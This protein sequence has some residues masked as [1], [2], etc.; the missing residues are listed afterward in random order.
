MVDNHWAKDLALALITSIFLGG[1]VDFG[2]SWFYH[3][4]C[5]FLKL[6]NMVQVLADSWQDET[7]VNLGGTEEWRVHEVNQE[8]AFQ[9]EVERHDSEDDSCELINNVEGSEANPVRKPLL[10]VIKTFWLKSHE[11]HE[12]WVSNTDDVGDVSLANA[13]HD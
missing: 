12:G 4:C 5:I 6:L 3:V 8:T 11:T 7:I 10:I 2:N 9:E 13:E 1:G